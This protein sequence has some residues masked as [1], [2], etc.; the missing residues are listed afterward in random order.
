MVLCV[1]EKSR[2]QALDRTQPLLPTTT[3]LRHAAVGATSEHHDFIAGDRRIGE[4]IRHALPTFSNAL[5]RK[6]ASVNV[7]YT[8]ALR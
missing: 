2:I 7:S 8:S 3:P 5:L 1:D 4:R 6:S